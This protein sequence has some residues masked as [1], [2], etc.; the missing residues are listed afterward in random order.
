MPERFGSH[1]LLL[2]H[3]QV[4]LDTKEQVMVRA[5]SGLFFIVA[6]TSALVL[7]STAIPMVASARRRCRLHVTS[8]RMLS[9][10]RKDF[11][12]YEREGRRESPEEQ[13]EQLVLL[14]YRLNHVLSLCPR[15]RRAKALRKRV[16]GYLN[17]LEEAE[18][19][20]RRQAQAK[21][22]PRASAPPA[23]PIGRWAL[24]A[25]QTLGRFSKS[26]FPAR[27]TP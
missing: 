10:I 25:R 18:R 11:R 16:L 1:L 23:T 6:T 9:G 20:R 14:R 17:P 22:P 7:L 13:I 21:P 12:A 3:C 8:S 5:R 24:R 4:S 15:F 27:A 2:L 26:R 19:A